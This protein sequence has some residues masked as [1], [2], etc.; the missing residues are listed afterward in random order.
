MPLGSAPKTA[1]NIDFTRAQ[2]LESTGTITFEPPRVVVGTTILS[3]RPV[4]V[5]ISGGLGDI[6][7]VRLPA[8]T[9]HVVEKI[10][11]QLPYEWDFALPTSSSA[12]LNYEDISGSAPVPAIY[13]YARSVNGVIPDPVTGNI[14]VTAT[15]GPHTH[16]TTDIVGFNAAV[17]ALA[18]ASASSA[19]A[20]LIDAAPGTL[21]TLNELAAALG[22]D[23]NFAATIA[24]QIAT[25]QPADAD[26]TAIAALSP[27]DG[28]LMARVLGAWSTQTI[29]QVK[30]SLGLATVA[31]SGA[32][33][34]LSGKPT[35]PSTAGE[36]GAIP[37]SLVDAAGDLLVG[38]AD[39]T[40]D[41]LAK[42]SN[43]KV[44]GVSAGSVS[45]IDPPA[46]G[47]A[48]DPGDDVLSLFGY[49]SSVQ[50][51]GTYRNSFGQNNEIWIAWIMVRAGRPINKISTFVS[52]AGVL[53]AGGNNGF[54][55]A[56][57]N[58][59]ALLY[60]VIDNN[61]WDTQGL[62]EKSLGASAIPAQPVD[63]A[64]RVELSVAGYST[65]P[66]MCLS[67]ALSSLSDYQG[68]AR[69][70]N[71]AGGFQ[72]GGAYNPVTF[73]GTTGGNWPLIM[74]G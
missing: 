3:T 54:G 23:P 14:V 53:G 8:G 12:S 29:A 64:Y 59:S 20:A 33:A 70:G 5:P 43:G 28:S 50:P 25:K 63:T 51:I 6:S 35:I 1:I 10:D 9:Y 56:T 46:G 74:L 62:R 37:V 26:L 67:T 68:W 45:W 2:G 44:L 69:Y 66:T 24:A 57:A 27:A 47:L 11:N 36:V 65:P 22:D 30:T 73:G 17:T 7:L 4:E 40:I 52:A 61:L 19:V 72:G 41:R 39:N 21:D 18:N 58:G 38:S 42:G 15:A 48:Y 49:H 31:T 71:A 32:Y 16:P 55:I 34:D 60:S 13:T